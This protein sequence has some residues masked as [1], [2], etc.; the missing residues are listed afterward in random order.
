MTR[1]LMQVLFHADVMTEAAAEHQHMKFYSRVTCVIAMA[2]VL[3]GI[4][5]DAVFYPG[6]VKEFALARTL[7][8]GAIA[9][10][11]RSYAMPFGGR[12]I[13]QMTYLWIALPQ[14]MIS[15]MIYRT[16]GEASVYFVGLTL[17]VAGIG[18]FLPLNIREAIGYSLFTTVAYVIAC[19]A[20]SGGVQRWDQLGGQLIFLTFFSVIAATVSIYS[21]RWRRRTLSLQNEVARQRNELI[22]NNRALAEVKGQL[23]HREK[24]VALGTLS[25]GL[26]HEVNNPVNYSL[27]ALNM[28]LMDASVEQHA[29]LK[30]N[31]MD[32]KEGMER[33]QNIVSDLKT[34]AYQ[35]PGEEVHRPFL[36]EKAIQSALRL[37]SHELKGIDVRCHLP[38]DTHVSGDEPAVIGVMI[39]LLS[40]AANA[41]LLVRREQPGIVIAAAVV[42]DRLV[43]TVRDNG[44][45]VLPE[46]IERVFEPFFTTR[47]VGSGLGLG[48]SICY[49]IIQRHGGVLSVRSEPG[50]WTEFTF[51]LPRPA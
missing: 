34:F 28:A 30:E 37:T 26:L 47:D 2:L 13:R 6:N 15:W 50:A 14:V 43:V 7:V 36:L 1:V 27:M 42:D 16:D 23:L 24:M 3:S 38:M 17:G 49:G 12:H 35:K 8:A 25:A 11:L 40:N 19:M 10:I 32:A 9:M 21:G 22:N 33:V 48:L 44:E 51:D 18:V 31:L 20:R 29:L 41:V 46:N 4:G 5:L 39:N 45:G